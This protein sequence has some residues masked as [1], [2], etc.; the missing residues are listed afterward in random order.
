MAR[1]PQRLGKLYDWYDNRCR[2][3]QSRLHLLVEA[4]SHA[5]EAIQR[6]RDDVLA[7]RMGVIQAAEV[8]VLELAALG[9]FC[10]QAKVQE[11][12]LHEKRDLAIRVREL[13]RQVVF[14]ARQQ[15]QLFEK[16]R[17]RRLA[18][19]QYQEMRELE[20]LASESY[21]AGFVR[22]LNGNQFS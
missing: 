21:L 22:E 1:F 15:L 16:L 19:F 5:E 12:R 3:E 20:E 11:V 2:L 13:Q 17:D 4:A 14:A 7:Q 6:H 18:E 8:Q 9:A 10:H